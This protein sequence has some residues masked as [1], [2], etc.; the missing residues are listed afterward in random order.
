MCD[1]VGA[2]SYECIRD[3]MEQY[4]P[5]TGSRERDKIWWKSAIKHR[6][7]ELVDRGL[8]DWDKTPTRGLQLQCVKACYAVKN[9]GG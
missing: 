3:V 9:M 4:A 1:G 6:L 5:P 7:N 2:F 8:I